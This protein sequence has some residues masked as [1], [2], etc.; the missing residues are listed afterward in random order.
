MGLSSSIDTSLSKKE[1]ESLVPIYD[2]FKVYPDSSEVGLIESSM[3]TCVFMPPKR[4][5]IKIETDSSGKIIGAPSWMDFKYVDEKLENGQQYEVR[6]SYF[7]LHPEKKYK[8]DSSK[9]IIWSHGNASDLISTYRLMEEYYEQMKGRVGI[10]AYDYEGYGYSSG[11]YSEKNSYNDLTLMVAHAIRNMKINKDNLLLVGQ[12]LGT[13]VV[14]DFC[15]THGW[16]TP[17]SLISPYESIVKVV[18]GTETSSSLRSIDMFTTYTK[19]D[20]LLC[21]III[22]HGENDELI[23]PKHSIEMYENN[24]GRN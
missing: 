16:T 18:S 7:V 4:E 1:S 11:T 10:I 6:L 13:G 20:D 12:S 21:R 23:S 15:H 3:N 5:E 24:K 9:Y 14:V 2:T 19:I 8:S 22:Y 17:I